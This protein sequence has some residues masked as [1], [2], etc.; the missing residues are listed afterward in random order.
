MKTSK[1][2]FKA[3]FPLFGFFVP[4]SLPHADFFVP[5][6]LVA[7]TLLMVM[8][9]W[10]SP[11]GELHDVSDSELCHFCTEHGLHYSNMLDHIGS[12]SDQK[13]SGWRLIERLRCIGR[14]DRPHEHVPALGTLDSFH[15]QCL[16]SSDGRDVLKNKTTL[17]NLISGTYNGGGKAWKKWELRHL[18]VQQKRQMLQAWRQG[19]AQSQA[20]PTAQPAPL[21]LPDYGSCSQTSTFER[22]RASGASSTRPESHKVSRTCSKAPLNAPESTKNPTPNAYHG[23]EKPF[24]NDRSALRC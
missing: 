6:S 16:S 9:T 24:T 22:A 19:A 15:K 7:P 5:R 17:S 20:A 8:R 10:V 18:T 11:D 1:Q 12:R 21:Q 3:H 13:N 2:R 14:V 4:R 23:P